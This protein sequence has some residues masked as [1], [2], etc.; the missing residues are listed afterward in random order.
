MYTRGVPPVFKKMGY[1]IDESSSNDDK[2]KHRLD[3]SRVCSP[4]SWFYRKTNIAI[5]VLDCSLGV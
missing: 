4:V 3:R 1:L 5:C 2:Y